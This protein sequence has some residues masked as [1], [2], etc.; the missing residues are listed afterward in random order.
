MNASSIAETKERRM[1]EYVN[2]RASETLGQE[3]LVSFLK[4]RF[5][6]ATK[7]IGRAVVEGTECVEV[8]VPSNSPEFEEI[9]KFI[10]ARRKQGQRG[11]SDFTIGWY[12]RKYTKAELQNAEVLRLTIASHFEPSG[13]ECG[14]IYETLCNHCNWGRQVSDLILDLRR[15][16]Q[17][18]DISETIAWVEWVVSSKFARTFTENKL[19]GAE[20]RPIFEFKNPTKK[21]MDWYQ[22]RVTGKAGELAESTRLGRDPFSPSQ[23]SWR[24][25]LGHSVVTEF[26]S[27]IYL[28]RSAWDGSDIAITSALFGQGRNLLRPT[29]L[30]IVSQRMYRLLQEAGLKGFSV[31]VA[32]LV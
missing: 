20:F 18:K 7:P 9:R 6:E 11:F 25:P 30:I 17:H 29:P 2:V 1:T 14:T 19:A 28:Q 4:S 15:V 24:C 27:E 21:S 32:H 26:L 16:P 22:L 31:E 13:E 12:L 5:P 3:E 8:R 10:D 23:I